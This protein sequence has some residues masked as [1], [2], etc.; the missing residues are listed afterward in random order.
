M[1]DLT[2]NVRLKIYKYL[3]FLPYFY[4]THLICKFCFSVI[5]SIFDNFDQVFIKVEIYSIAVQDLTAG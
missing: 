3:N 4:Q 1:M 2:E 5:F